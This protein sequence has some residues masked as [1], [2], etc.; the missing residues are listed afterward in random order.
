MPN[1]V[2]GREIVPELIQGGV[3]G[4]AIAAAGRAI[5]D[6]AARRAEIVAGLRDVRA[7]LGRGGA[8]ER[9]AGIAAEM[10]GERGA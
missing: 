10:L 7:R 8:A 5:L 6:D 2:A 4:P 1:I 9:A 3:T